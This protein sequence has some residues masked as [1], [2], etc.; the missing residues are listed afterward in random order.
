M[1]VHILPRVSSVH[2]SRSSVSSNHVST[3]TTGKEGKQ[4]FGLSQERQYG[5]TEETSSN[6]PIFFPL[7]RVEL[8][9]CFKE[10]VKVW[11]ILFHLYVYSINKTLSSYGP[12]NPYLVRKHLVY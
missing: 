5:V 1:R 8:C 10:R 2:G 7:G 4:T 9:E 11:F 3:L 6:F 12:F